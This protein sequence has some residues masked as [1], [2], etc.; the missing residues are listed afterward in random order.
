MQKQ[1]DEALRE[2]TEELD[3]LNAKAT[4][5]TQLIEKLVRQEND[6]LQ[7]THRQ[8][9]AASTAR[10]GKIVYSR[11]NSFGSNL[12]ESWEDGY[13]AVDLTE[14]FKDLKR[15][16]EVRERMKELSAK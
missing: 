11:A 1:F 3:S 6:A 15:R 8:K 14:Q 2:K 7:R 16:R 13:A 4:S 9:L 12:I 10:L 5:N